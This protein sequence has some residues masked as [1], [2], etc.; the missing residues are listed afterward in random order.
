MRSRL[1]E[2]AVNGMKN[3]ISY[4]KYS[5]SCRYFYV[6]QHLGDSGPVS[7]TSFCGQTATQ[8]GAGREVNLLV[9]ST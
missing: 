3:Q 5:T 8:A 7:V 2:N 9:S 4:G 6:L 1:D